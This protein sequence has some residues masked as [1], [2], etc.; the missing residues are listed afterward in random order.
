MHIIIVG[1]SGFVGQALMSY[2]KDRGHKVEPLSIRDSSSVQDISYALQS[3]DILINLAGL[4]IFGRWNESYKKALYN[5]RIETTKKLLEALKRCEKRPKT[6]ISTSAIG[7]YPNE[8]SCDENKEDFSLSFLSKICQD[9]EK[10]ALKAR[11]LGI[12]TSI[13]R[14]GVV[15]GKS[16]GM[17]KK[18]WLPFSFGLGGKLGS[19]N[20]S[21]SWIHI[22]D[23]CAAYNMLIDKELEG[24]YNLCSPEPTTNLELT[25]TLGLLMKR[26]TLLPV[27]AFILRLI[28][29]EG[30]NFMLEGQKVF[31]KKL[32]D[33]G[34]EF[35]YTNIK[36][37]LQSFF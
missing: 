24:T 17:I 30:A 7:I 19:G 3:C 29:G 18:I 15:L 21:L 11:T 1:C 23:L 10:E 37:A 20:Q 6:F 8:I 32:L 5:S 27:P 2:L 4:S 16:G 13:F 9:W 33:S 26:P 12:K 36:E 25:K 31:P 34:F 22:E 28:F 35:K 14:F